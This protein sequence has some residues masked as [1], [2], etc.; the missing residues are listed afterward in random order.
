MRCLGEF[1]KL[2]Y[3]KSHAQ[4]LAHGRHQ[5]LAAPSC[6]G[7]PIPRQ[8]AP[9]FR[10]TLLLKHLAAD[11]ITCSLFAGISVH[12]SCS[13]CL[14]PEEALPGLGSSKW[15]PPETGESYNYLLST[16]LPSPVRTYS[17]LWGY[18]GEPGRPGPALGFALT[19][20]S[21]PRCAKPSC[22]ISFNPL[23]D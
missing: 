5:A 4:C 9:R 22:V 15:K 16:C 12:V 8:G 18:G 10:T 3:I 14:F 11:L 20:R 7:H 19:H 1:G 17:R 21:A 2:R 6:S 23:R 13:I